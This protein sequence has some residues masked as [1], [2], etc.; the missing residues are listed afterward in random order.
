M[1]KGML[2]FITLLM[3]IFMLIRMVS[4]IM[5]EMFHVRISLNSVSAAASEFCEWFQV[6]IESIRLLLTHLHGFQLLVLLP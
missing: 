2:R 1:H 4:V 3:I 5:L 6:G